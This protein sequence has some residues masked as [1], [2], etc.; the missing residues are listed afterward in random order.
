MSADGLKHE[1]NLSTGWTVAQDVNNLGEVIEVYRRDWDAIEHRQTSFS[2]G[3]RIERLDYLQ[4]LLSDQPY[5]GRHLRQFNAAPWFYRLKFDAP[6]QAKGATLRFE[7]VDYYA[8]VWLND[9]LLGEH[10][11][12]VEA[13]EF[14]V[15]HLLET[16]RPNVLVVKVW[17]P[18]EYEVVPGLV[19]ER[20]WYVLRT[21][22]KGSYEHADT[23]V[24]RDVNPVGIWRPVKLIVH[25]GLRTSARPV[26]TATPAADGS[27]AKV[28]IVWP[29][30]LKEGRVKGDLVLRIFGPNSGREVGRTS[31]PVELV[32]GENELS[33]AAKIESPQLWSTWDR[34]G[35][36]VYEARLAIVRDDRTLLAESVSFGVREVA[37]IRTSDKTQF[38]LN[39]KN[40]YLRGAT[41][42]P[43]LYV[44]AS[45]KARYERDLAAAIA[46]GINAL[47]IHVHVEND[48]FYDLCDRLG[49]LVFQDFELTWAFPTTEEFAARA[50]RVFG[51]MVKRLRNHPSVACWI[52]MNEAT[53][54]RASREFDAAGI[55]P[56]VR[57]GRELAAEARRLDPARPI[58]KNSWATDDPESGDEHDYT[59][60]LLPG[61]FID[62]AARSW[63]LLTEF[64]VDAPPGLEGIRK[65]PER[66]ARLTE[67]LPRV[68]EL[69]DYQYHLIKFYVERCRISK[70]AP[71]SGYFQFM[72][73]DFTPQSC[74]GLYDFWGF[75]KSE[76][77]GG[78]VRAMQESNQPVGVF[79]EYN[80]EGSVALHAANDTL[81]DLGL[82]QASWE[83]LS[84]NG[85]VLASG[86]AA[87]TLGPDSHGRICDLRLPVRKEQPCE[88]GLSLVTAAGRVLARNRYRNPFNPPARPEGYPKRVDH[89]VGMR[90]WWSVPVIEKHEGVSE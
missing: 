13:F 24:Q 30:A 58:I 64:G 88:V 66:A 26:V 34:G 31:V 61:E 54:E 1:I 45:D 27:E 78:G 11:G 68:A 77:I 15:G 39:G 50:V 22:F 51:G 25:D 57:P 33:L 90:L 46:I 41:Y 6:P 75:P 19:K 63:K 87:V 70:Y 17:S 69:H 76:G 59:G 83:C 84:P 29:V 67:V 89:D 21:M 55:D 53:G 73:I 16:G 5:F 43:D 62:V 80:R 56:V 20:F 47:R 9:T 79:M 12:H 35:A 14:E 4:R 3:E 36:N 28:G 38:K 82:C 71:N 81:A 52:C 86:Q 85:A 32:A 65:V 60:S 48:E 40:F 10:E 37:I 74:Y 7:G 42:W 72:F 49:V 44:S 8:K 18:M 2:P 23:F